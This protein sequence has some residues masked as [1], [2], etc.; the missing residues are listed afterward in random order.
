MKWCYR[1][2]SSAADALEK[3]R[4]KSVTS[5]LS[6]HFGNVILLFAPLQRLQ[7]QETGAAEAPP[8]VA[9]AH[10]LFSR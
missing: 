2:A 8:A 7:Q 6:T 3:K 5:G 4:K 9:G 10:D 1:G